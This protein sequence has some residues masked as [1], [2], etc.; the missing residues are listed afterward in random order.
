MNKV[1]YLTL[2]FAIFSQYLSSQENWQLLNPR[3]S[4]ATGLDIEFISD[5]KGFYIT[6]N[7]LFHTTDAGE[8][9]ELKQI[10]NGARDI[11]FKDGLGI[12]AESGS[13]WISKNDGDTWTKSVVQ[14]VLN[15]ASIIDSNTIVVSGSNSI[16]ISTDQG[17]N[18]LQK[19]IPGNRVNK[20]FFLTKD[21]GHAVTDN[22]EIYKTIDGGENWNTTVSFTNFIPNSFF[23]IYFKNENVGFAT[24]EHSAFYKTTD[25]GETWTEINDGISN[26]IF[27]FQFINDMIGFGAGEYG[28]YK[29]I[30]GGDTWTRIAVENAYVYATDM[31]GIYFLNENEGFSVGQR[32]RIAKTTDSGENWELYSP[33]NTDVSQIE[34]LSPTRALARVGSD[35]YSSADKG[36][37]WQYLSTPRTGSYT[38][39]FDFVDDNIGYCIAGGSV[40]TSSRADKVYKTTDGGSSWFEPTNFGLNVDPGLYSIEFVD[41]NLGFASGGFNQKRLF[42]TTDGGEIWRVVFQQAMGQIQFLNEDIGYARRF[43]FST[44]IVYKT[45]DGG[46]NWTEIF[47]SEKDIGAFYFL[48]VNLGFLVGQDGLG[49]KTI[50]GGLTWVKLELPYLDF[51]HVTFYSPNIGYAID[52]D[53]AIYKTVNSGSSWKQIYRNYGLND[54]VITPEDEVFIAGDFGRILKSQVTYEN[55]DLEVKEATNITVSS[56]NIQVIVA[57]N[58]DEAT[59]FSLQYGENGLYDN[60][61]ELNPN[62]VEI[63]SFL[64]IEAL[65]S[66]LKASTTYNYRVVALSDGNEVVSNIGMFTTLPNYILNMNFVYQPGADKAS[67]SGTITANNLD[68]SAVNF[69]YG[70]S[71]NTYADLV[72]ASP[73]SVVG[74]TSNVNVEAVLQNL[75]AETTYYVRIKAEYEGKTIYSNPVNF[76]TKP[77][78]RIVTYNPNIVGDQANISAYLFAYKDDLTEIV[79]EYGEQSFNDEIN[80]TPDT[81]LVD[82]SGNISATISGLETEKIYYYR[83]RAKQGEEIIYGPEGIFS[84]SENVVLLVDEDKDIYREYVQ[85]NGKVFTQSGFLSTIQIEYGTTTDYGFSAYASPGFSSA[86]T[87]TSIRSTLG[88][89]TPNT[90]YNYRIKATKDDVD[91]FSENA[92]FTTLGALPLDNFKII[93][94]SETCIAKNNG[95]LQIESTVQSNYTA[96]LGFEQYSFTD[97][98]LVENLMSGTYNLC[99]REN[100]AINSKCFQFEINE[101]EQIS[102]KTELKNEAFG[103]Q[104]KVY[105][106]KGTFPYIVTIN[107]KKIGEFNSNSFGFSV[108]EGD[109]IEIVSKYDCEGKIVLE[110]PRETSVDLFINPVSS[111]ADFL[112]EENDRTILLEL[113]DLNG[114]LLESIKEYVA[115]NRILLNMEKYP[116]GLYLIKIQGDTTRTHKLLKQ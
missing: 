45:I 5:T 60:S 89:L 68:I 55:V 63:G 10:L 8:N 67:V 30:N 66:G 27:S 79:V 44:D 109:A 24:R 47:S 3:P 43:G 71:P 15:T 96:T 49:Y 65:I 13:V 9:W 103:K 72:E 40:G 81:I 83:I 114:G 99:I 87:T 80:T 7:E 93:V 48:D 16:F 58:G 54:F 86:G 28:M 106:D 70:T 64:D 25:G 29:T 18:W 105:M 59:N 41:E 11:S 94:S 73:N 22:G 84:L 101:S 77:N 111:M 92:T 91:Y 102:G 110:I 113:F 57:A 82:A 23:T 21:I 36:I 35:F 19:D 74:G 42:K 108:Q 38:S 37:S 52:D 69:E 112:V 95:T 33:I 46:E 78:F 61:V 115:N 12:I 53:G 116:S 51:E 100:G 98:L 32:G 34:Y 17:V 4:T 50:D 39:D 20:T 6:S 104:L 26:A 14:E 107:D 75:E 56:A 2:L 76:I 90:L 31:F 88:N 85:V 1:K 62:S 97:N